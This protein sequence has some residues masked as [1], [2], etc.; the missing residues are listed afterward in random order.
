LLRV[1]SI[2]IILGLA[3]GEDTAESQLLDYHDPAEIVKTEDYKK[4]KEGGLKSRTDLALFIEGLLYG[5]I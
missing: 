2:A 4:A 3:I 5:I 1:L